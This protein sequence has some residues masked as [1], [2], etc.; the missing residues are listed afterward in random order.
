MID[1]VGVAARGHLA[2]KNCTQWSTFFF[3][4]KAGNSDL[5][6]SEFKGQYIAHLQKLF[7][8]IAISSGIH[9]G[10]RK[11]NVVAFDYSI[12]ILLQNVAFIFLD[13]V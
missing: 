11:P 8:E 12:R 10:S 9:P 6:S 3:C 1:A 4:H 5:L 7:D 2:C 13:S